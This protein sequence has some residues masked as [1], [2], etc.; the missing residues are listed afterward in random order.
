[1][2]IVMMMNM[3]MV[4]HTQLSIIALQ[5]A[6]IVEPQEI[7]VCICIKCVTH[8]TPKSSTHQENYI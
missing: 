4:G 8:K 2:L 7:R 6:E 3:L 5:C 1:M